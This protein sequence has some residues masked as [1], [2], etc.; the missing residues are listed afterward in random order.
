MGP[1][2]LRFFKPFAG[3]QPLENS[4]VCT[5]AAQDCHLGA[6]KK[7][8]PQP[9]DRNLWGRAG[10]RHFQRPQANPARSQGW[11]RG[12]DVPSRARG[13]GS[14]R[15]ERARPGPSLPACPACPAVPASCAYLLPCPVTA[16]RSLFRA[17]AALFGF[18]RTPRRWRGGRVVAVPPRKA[19]RAAA[20]GVPGKR[21][22]RPGTAAARPAPS[23]ARPP[24]GLL[25]AELLGDHLAQLQAQPVGHALRQVLV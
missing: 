2:V 22:R 11:G 12:R 13:L 15:Q 5:L 8:T 21:R 25:V 18:S 3:P 6:F 9:S 19:E 1:G 14:A 7:P 20:E 17:G 24:P 23:P 16:R 4:E 10:K